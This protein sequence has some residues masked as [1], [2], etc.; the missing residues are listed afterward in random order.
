MVGKYP[1]KYTVHHHESRVY[2]TL[3]SL[4]LLKLVMILYFTSTF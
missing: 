4:E 3:H 1:C 2:N